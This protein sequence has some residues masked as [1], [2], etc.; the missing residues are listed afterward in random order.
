MPIPWS[1]VSQQNHT[2]VPINN[3]LPLTEEPTYHDRLPA[4]DTRFTGSLYCT[5][6]CLTPTLAGCYQYSVE[7][8]SQELQE[9]AAKHVRDGFSIE[10]ITDLVGSLADKKIVEPQTLAGEL[11]RPGP[12]VISGD[13]INSALVR[14]PVQSLLNAPMERV[15][16]R[17][18]AYR[19]FSPTDTGMKLFYVSEADYS[20]EQPKVTLDELDSGN[21]LWP[22]ES[23]A[24]QLVSIAS[25][26]GYPADRC[27]L[28][29]GTVVPN[30]RKVYQ[31]LYGHNS[32]SYALEQK[33]FL[34]RYGGNLDGDFELSRRFL[35][36]HDEGDANDYQCLLVAPSQG[37][38]SVEVTGECLKRFEQTIDHM[39]DIE[40]GHLA[41]HPLLDRQEA[42]HVAQQMNA[43]DAPQSRRLRKGEVVWA[44][45]HQ[46][47]IVSFGRWRSY[48]WRYR[49]TVL[50]KPDAIRPEV[51][52][53]DAE[54]A[55]ASGNHFRLTAGRSMHGFVVTESRSKRRLSD[56]LTESIGES[57]GGL[58]GRVHASPAKEVIRDGQDRFVGR[59]EHGFCLLAPPVGS[60]KVSSAEIYLRQNQRAFEDNRHDPRTMAT[61]GEYEDDQ[62]A[63]RLAGRKM[64]PHAKPKFEFDCTVD[65]ES[66]SSATNAILG[67]QTPLMRLVSQPNV[68]F[69]FVLRLE[70]LR[71]WELG[72]IV[73]SL[74]ATRLD[75]RALLQKLGFDSAE[76]LRNAIASQQTN[77]RVIPQLG[78]VFEGESTSQTPDFASKI[79]YQRRHGMGSVAV[80]V[81]HQDRVTFADGHPVVRQESSES[82][83][84]AKQAFYEFLSSSLTTASDR[85]KY[86]GGVL[87]PWLDARQFQT[88]HTISRRYRNIGGSTLEYHKRV[89][90]WHRKER[91]AQE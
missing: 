70:N 73:F 79:G 24:Q 41:G 42:K 87:A 16:E 32:D 20:G 13:A 10:E 85:K 45:S 86:V 61:W 74:S 81:D 46:G 63:G 7:Q 91:H 77:E 23:V 83:N 57:L 72:A 88:K 90:E 15:T 33:Y 68:E 48:L 40:V 62:L 39:R 76:K 18:I 66:G 49:D 3:R 69:R 82:F 58:A 19:V 52:P 78:W 75:A 47:S 34:Y 12:V 14:A 54:K 1:Q 80:T 65:V 60:P 44:E 56:P 50:G 53:L 59:S 71:L 4:D 28:R 64:F 37:G 6:T 31:I 8:A 27:E 5:M 43:A 67:P 22:R 17:T 26:Q 55:P 51:R 21:V 11:N 35:E 36:R 25:K 38:Q 30:T 29:A 89:R 2:F 9:A 84:Q